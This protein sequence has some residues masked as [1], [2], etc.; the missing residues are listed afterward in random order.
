MYKR[1]SMETPLPPPEAAQPRRRL[2]SQLQFAELSQ[3]VI[4]FDWDDTLFPTT[5]L[6]EDFRV[7]WQLPVAAQVHL[8]VAER[9]QIESKLRHCEDLAIQVLL[10]STSRGHVVIVTLARSGWVD[11]ACQQ[12]YPRLGEVLRNCGVPIVYALER[13]PEPQLLDMRARGAGD[14]E[15]YGLVKGR[16]IS[17]EIERFYSQYEGQTWKNVLSVGDSRF[18]RFG[19]LAA[20]TAYMM[21]RRMSAFDLLPK[22]P[23]EHEAWEL[24][25]DGQRLVRLRVKCC[26]L[27]ERPDADELAVELDMLSRWLD[28]MTSLDAGFDLDVEALIGEE[29]VSIAEAVL[30]GKRPTEDM[31]KLS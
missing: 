26:K 31:P 20:A 14:E 1:Y 18:E 5:A 19:L 6:L 7:D 25:A 29:E 10:R 27:L 23:G 3:T 15:I 8:P 28:P 16:A 21:G 24:L 2:N 22:L 4:V 12:Y 17:E 9:L 11:M 13:V 30:Q